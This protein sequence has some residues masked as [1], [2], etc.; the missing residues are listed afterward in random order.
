MNSLKKRTQE[1]KQ[2]KATIWCFT[3]I[4]QHQCT[5]YLIFVQY[6]RDHILK[7]SKFIYTLAN[8]SII[9]PH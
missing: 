1:K 9:F 8:I 4:I 2:K 6:S 7:H 3:M 5:V